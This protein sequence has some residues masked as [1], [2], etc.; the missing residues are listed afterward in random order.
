MIEFSGVN[1]A[2][3]GN[4]IL[5]EINARFDDGTIT[6]IAGENGAGKSTMLRLAMGLI[7]PTTGTV[8][9]NGHDTKAARVSAIARDCGYLFQNPDRQIFGSTALS[10]VMFGLPQIIDGETVK[11]RA[12]SIL[13]ELAI[14]PSVNPSTLSRGERQR[15]ALA[16]LIVKRP[17][18]LLIDEP[19]TGLDY[20]ECEQIMKLIVSLNK[21]RGTT[22]VMITHDMEVAHDYAPNMVVLS[23]GHIVTR[24][25]TRTIMR[26]TKL[27]EG[28][29]LMPAQLAG[30]AAMIDAPEGVD[31]TPESF[32]AYIRTEY[33]KKH[34]ATH[35]TNKTAMGEGGA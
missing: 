28:A 8:T 26:D 5:H 3:D 12:L 30:L 27:L 19:T 15:L 25:G 24:G 11:E 17:K 35:I 33:E 22:V 23:R 31:D 1:Y 29:S 16:G 20:S 9:V 6:A 14:D 18:T 10:E 7:K 21:S 32:A 2:I 13:A 4:A 34:A